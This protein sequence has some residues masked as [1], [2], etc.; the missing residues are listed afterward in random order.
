LGKGLALLADILNPDM[1]IVGTLGVVL[2]DLLLEPARAALREEA[3]PITAEA[4]RVVP[5]QLGSNLGKVSALMAAIDAHHTGRLTLD[6]YSE[7][8]LVLTSLR[9]G[10]EVRQRLIE[11]QLSQIM[12]TGQLL[13][14]VFRAGGKVLL[15]GN[16]GSAATAQHLSGELIGRY[17]VNRVPL[18]AIALTADTSVV[19]CIGNDYAFD[20]VFA[21]QVRALARPGDLLVG[22]TTSGRSP[23]IL[24]AF[25][26][27]QA[28][29]IHTI[30]LTGEKGLAEPVASHIIKAP[31]SQAARI[32]EEHDAIL[33]AWCEMVDHA[34]GP[35]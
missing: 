26:A 18:P 15:C 4:C 22:F 34:Y 33:H 1:V 13:V 8:N 32:Q 35:A 30:A 28:A 23:N 27:A 16:G 25:R 5:A 17:K 20:E 2:G 14:D 29:G 24:S 11:T 3:L 9:A 21:R 7:E 31:S 6:D 10:L 19:T 12:T